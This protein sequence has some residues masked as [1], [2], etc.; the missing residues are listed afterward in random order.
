MKIQYLGIFS[1]DMKY[2]EN[3]KNEPINPEITEVPM[4]KLGTRALKQAVNEFD[5]R[6]TIQTTRLKYMNPSAFRLKPTSQYTG[7]V[8]R[9]AIIKRNGMKMRVFDMTYEDTR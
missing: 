9:R 4:I 5:M 8:Y 2:P 6:I 7:V 1:F 3:K